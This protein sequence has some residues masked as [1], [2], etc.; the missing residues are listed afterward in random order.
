MTLG[1]DATQQYARGGLQVH[2][3]VGKKGGERTRKPSGEER[4]VR[5]NKVQVAP[6]ICDWRKIETFRGSSVV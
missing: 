3:R 1:L 4:S 6:E 2:G 5:G